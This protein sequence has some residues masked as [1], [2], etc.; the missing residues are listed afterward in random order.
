MNDKGSGGRL[1]N[2]RRKLWLFGSGSSSSSDVDA[3]KKK[4]KKKKD[5]KK[6]GSDVSSVAKIKAAPKVVP[7]PSISL[8]A[9]V[10][11][12]YG[13][14]VTYK[15]DESKAGH[16]WD[17]ASLSED[18]APDLDRRMMKVLRQVFPSWYVDSGLSGLSPTTTNAAA[19]E[20]ESTSWRNP[21]KNT[22]A[23]PRSSRL[24]SFCLK[25]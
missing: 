2:N 18:D 4:S 5:K 24:N 25:Y 22:T 15:D 20:S 23:Y 3:D 1:S 7:V 14:P 9:C 19:E 10:L 8:A 6:G 11:A 16:G 12:V 17:G 13:S 21:L